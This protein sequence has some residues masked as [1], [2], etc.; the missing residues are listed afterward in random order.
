MIIPGGS[1]GRASQVE[2]N[3][4]GGDNIVV[5][6]KASRL[7]MYVMGQAVFSPKL[8]L[9]NHNP[10]SIHSIALVKKYDSVLGPMLD[11]VPDVDVVVIND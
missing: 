8:I 4:D 10:A 5:Q 7:G 3:L 9:R 6:A 1:T 11:D 2:V